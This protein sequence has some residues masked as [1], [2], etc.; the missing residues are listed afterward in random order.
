M[1]YI[2]GVL[3]I[4]VALT[5][6][7]SVSQNT[8]GR[9]M[10]RN[11]AG[12]VD[13]RFSDQDR[14]LIQDYYRQP[15]KHKKTPPGLAKRGGNLPPGLAK[16]DTLP[17]GLQGRGLPGDLEGSL[18][19]LPAGYVRVQIGADIVLMHRDTR[20]IFDIIYGVN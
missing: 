13:I 1:K 8:S 6:C 20:V 3:A 19:R 17:P 10:V 14:R 5:G 18:V 15:V 12:Y 16:R 7:V 9:V 4:T 11:E 2:T